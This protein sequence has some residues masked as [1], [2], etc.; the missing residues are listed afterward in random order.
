MRHDEADA[1]DDDQGERGAGGGDEGE[2]VDGEEGVGAV[3]DE[4]DDGVGAR[5]ADD[6]Q[7]GHGDGEQALGRGDDVKM[8]VWDVEGGADDGSVVGV[9]EE[10]ARVGDNGDADESDDGGGELGAGECLAQEDV[11]GPGGDEGDEKAEDG[12]FCEGQIVDRVWGGLVT[13]PV[14]ICRERYRYIV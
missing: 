7:K 8:A 2:V 11:A 3:A 5:G 1:R 6:A 12:G 10:G 13:I 14:Y 9:A 4:A